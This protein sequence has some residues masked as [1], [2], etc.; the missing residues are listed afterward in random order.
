MLEPKRIEV[1]LDD[2]LSD[3]A[4]GIR[5]VS[6]SYLSGRRQAKVRTAFM[7]RALEAM[8]KAGTV[9]RAAVG[10]AASAEREASQ[11]Q[12]MTRPP[13][14]IA[15]DA[16]PPDLVCLHTIREMDGEAVEKDAVAG[17]LEDLHPAVDRFIAV[18]VL[19]ESGHITETETEEGEDSGGS[20][21]S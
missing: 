6:C 8:A 11:L 16:N 3:L 15:T 1:E 2:R 7:V 18:R 5:I 17:W 13:E 10:K 4:G 12:R 21:D 19:R 14:E 20:P 9:D